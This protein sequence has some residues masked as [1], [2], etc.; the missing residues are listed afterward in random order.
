MRMDVRRTKP[1]L[2]PR[3]VAAKTVSFELESD[4]APPVDP[5]TSLKVWPDG[6]VFELN[7]FRFPW[8]DEPRRWIGMGRGE[9]E[10][11]HLPDPTVSREHATLGRNQYTGHVYVFDSGSHNGTFVNNLQV[12]GDPN[13][14][15]GGVEVISGAIVQLGGILLLACGQ[16]G[17]H[18]LPMVSGTTLREIVLHAVALYGGQEEAALKW[19]VTRSQIR[20]LLR[21]QGPN[22]G[23]DESA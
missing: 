19:G 8:R 9:D 15:G 20:T 18:Q 6:P 5:V 21:R 2:P 16:Q 13:W 10:S 17:V 1:K 7:A 12:P 11:I 3:L 14:Q 22:K 23:C 4:V